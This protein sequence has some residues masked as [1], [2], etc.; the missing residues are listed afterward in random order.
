MGATVVSSYWS[1]DLGK[2][3]EVLVDDTSFEEP[4][5]EKDEGGSGDGGDDDGKNNND[6]TLEDRMVDSLDDWEPT[7]TKINEVEDDV[8][9]D[10]LEPYSDKLD[11]A[12]ETLE[13]DDSNDG[14][15]DES[16]DE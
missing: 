2:I 12:E 7:V 15:L 6:G 3:D 8:L 10:S 9:Y 14:T 16:L 13:L 4:L 5:Y 1:D 11:S